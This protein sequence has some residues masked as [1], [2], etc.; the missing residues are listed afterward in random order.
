MT[1]DALD[2]GIFIELV[3]SDI[4]DRKHQFDVI[5]LRL[6][7]NSGD[8]FRAR[9]V[10]ERVANLDTYDVIKHVSIVRASNVRTA[11]PSKVFLKVNAIP[12]AMIRLSTYD[13]QVN[14]IRG[15]NKR[16]LPCPTCSRSIEF[17]Q[18]PW[19]HQGLQG[20]EAL[21]SPGPWRNSRVL[22]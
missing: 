1:H 9:L 22:S 16:P 5:L 18:I 11:T 4:I 12:P 17:Y 7:D 8:L 15:E 10:K 3:G 13:N 19:H 20:R 21:D 6:F 14:L 2:L